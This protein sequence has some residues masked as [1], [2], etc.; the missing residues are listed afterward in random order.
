M[1]PIGAPHRRQCFRPSRQGAPLQTDERAVTQFR[2]RHEVRQMPPCQAM[3]DQFLLHGV[4]RRGAGRSALD[5]E[6]I[7]GR[8]MAR[9][10]ADYA[11]RERLQMPG[12]ELA[13]LRARQKARRSDGHQPELANPDPFEKVAGGVG[14]MDDQ[15]CRCFPQPLER[16]GHGFIVERQAGVPLAGRESRERA[17]DQRPRTQ[18]AQH[19]PQHGL[20]AAGQR[21]RKGISR[22]GVESAGLAGRAP[23]DDG[24]YVYAIAN[25]RRTVEWSA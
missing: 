17:E 21:A 16:A 11:L 22:H 9:R 4:V 10:V 19:D 14:A 13:V 15:V 23:D 8:D 6:V 3:Q 24:R 18:I 1:A 7:L 12:S 5:Q 20:L 25:E 2:L